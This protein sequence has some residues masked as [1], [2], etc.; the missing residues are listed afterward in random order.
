M[1]KELIGTC[2][3]CSN[4]LI[5]TKLTCQVCN[6]EI[7]GEFELS[8]FSNLT[9]D[10]LYFVETFIQVYGSIKEM[11]KVLNISYPTVKKNLDIIV[12][13]MG[14]DQRSIEDDNEKDEILQKLQ[15]KEISVEEA[16]QLLKG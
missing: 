10:E 6:T 7:S 2:P 15:S 14:Y 1:R 16:L 11:E 9:K 4:K 13:K 3:V 12:K 5:A 8:R